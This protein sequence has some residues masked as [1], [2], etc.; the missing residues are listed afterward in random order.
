V[1]GLSEA[2]QKR[3]LPRA[4]RTDNGPAMIADAVAEGLLR[5]SIMTPFCFNFLHVEVGLEVMSIRPKR[6]S[7]LRRQ[8]DDTA[9]TSEG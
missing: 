4:L 3:G 2:I 5:L 9:P 1:H 6:T 7:I 8:I